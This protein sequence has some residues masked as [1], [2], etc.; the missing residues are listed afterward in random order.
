MGEG[1]GIRMNRIYKKPLK[2]FYITDLAKD[3][4]KRQT[5]TENLLWEKLRGRKFL[6]LKFRR[7]KP[8]GRYIA[9]FYC[10]EKKIILELD[11]ASHDSKATYDGKRDAMLNASHLSVIRIPND[12]IIADIDKVLMNIASCLNMT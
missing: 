4:R 1:R 11:G 2:P 5:D 3:L 7:Q 8:I 12:A 9:D 10:A 6:G